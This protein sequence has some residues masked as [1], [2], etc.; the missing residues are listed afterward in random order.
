MVVSFF[1][2]VY[3]CSVAI[4]TTK[5]EQRTTTGYSE[6]C[7]RRLGREQ[8]MSLWS[9]A[10]TFSLQIDWLIKLM[11]IRSERM[12]R[13][14]SLLKRHTT[15]ALAST[16]ICTT[17]YLFGCCSDAN[18]KKSFTIAENMQIARETA[19][20]TSDEIC[21]RFNGTHTLDEMEC[22]G[23][24]NGQIEWMHVCNERH[25]AT[26]R[27]CRAV[28]FFFSFLSLFISFSLFLLLPSGLFHPSKLWRLAGEFHRM[29]KPVVLLEI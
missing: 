7:M 15:M 9:A 17:F 6:K 13:S 24:R 27:K 26:R 12:R 19:E 23:E 22:T 4:A 16:R 25:A 2:M 14:V 10:I 1:E 21:N 5:Y 11:S 20:R 3:S 8:Q 29:A 28:Q 18:A